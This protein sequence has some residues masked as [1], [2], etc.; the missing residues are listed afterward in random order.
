MI[1][2]DAVINLDCFCDG[3]CARQ[4]PTHSAIP[5]SSARS[6][7]QAWVQLDRNSWAYSAYV[8]TFRWTLKPPEAPDP[9][10]RVGLLPNALKVQRPKMT[11]VASSNTH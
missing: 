8:I 10:F 2:H 9:W 11:H 6:P 5:L 7:V 4:D 1:P 3:A